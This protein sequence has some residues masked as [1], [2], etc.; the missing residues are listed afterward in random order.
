MRILK[1]ANIPGSRNSGMG[2]VMHSTADELRVMGHTVDF[3]FSQDVP[4]CRAG[5]SDRVAFP[6]ALVG[7]VRERM[8][9]HGAYDVV[10]IHEPSAA[11]YCFLRRL[12]KL[13]PPCAL[14]SHG[15][16]ELQWR[17]RL[18]LDQELGVSTSLKS[19]MLVPG[20]LLS[21]ARYALRHCQQ[22]MCLN[23]YDEHHLRSVLRVPERRLTRV[24]NGVDAKFFVSPARGDRC[25]SLL[26]VG[27]WL[28]KKGVRYLCSAFERLKRRHPD[29]QLS[30]LGVGVPEAEVLSGF[31]PDLHGA[32]RVR[33]RVDDNALLAAYASHDVL[34]FPTYYE[35]WG[36]VLTEAAAAGMAIVTTGAGGPADFFTDGHDAVLV[37]PAQAAPFAEAVERLIGD[38]AL[39]RRLGA[40]AQQR[41]RKFT[42]RAAA[43]S[44]LNAYQ[45]AIQNR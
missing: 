26:F 35:P 25:R 12:D 20:T 32:I 18:E 1:V 42:W 38:P 45:N 19:R 33:E 2:R 13:L 36:L 37:P 29:L 10:E 43:E 39:R 17:L 30:L 16:E 9:N 34:M 8:R 41:A 31:P 4:R 27:S 40:N 7:A 22:V 23:T 3:L 44:H 5:R 28:E 24:Q 21:Q 6:V 15:L 14:M 11:W